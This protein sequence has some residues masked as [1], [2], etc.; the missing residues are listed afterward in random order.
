MQHAMKSSPIDVVKEYFWEKMLSVCGGYMPGESLW[1]HSNGVNGKPTFHRRANLS[2]LS[3]ICNR[4]GEIAA[5]SRKSLTSIKPKWRFFWEKKTPYGQIFTNVFQSPTCGHGNTSFCANFMKFGRPEVGEIARYLMDQKQNFGS[6]SCCR[7]CADR[8]QNL[9]G[10]APNNRLGVPK[11]HPNPFTS[12][13]VIAECVNIIQMCHK[14]FAILGEASASLP[15]NYV[16]HGE[17]TQTC[18]VMACAKTWI[19]TAW[20]IWGKN[21]GEATRGRKKMHLLSNLMEKQVTWK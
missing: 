7:F 20:Y 4:F 11:F 21:E 19:I 14:V 10:T 17:K 15:S 3:K 18:V 9:S 6:L 12:V 8:A 2:W 1:V 13:G 16:R 5:G